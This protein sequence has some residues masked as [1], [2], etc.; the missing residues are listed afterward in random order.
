[1]PCPDK[2]NDKL[3]LLEIKRRKAMQTKSEVPKQEEVVWNGEITDVTM[4]VQNL[5]LIRTIEKIDFQTYVAVL[6][7][8]NAKIKKG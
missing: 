2:N 5:N 1:M 7:I 6:E 4:Y 3:I 8:E